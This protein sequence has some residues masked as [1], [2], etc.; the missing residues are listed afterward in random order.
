MQE[1]IIQILCLLD[2]SAPCGTSQLFRV[3]C[4]VVQPA[5]APHHISLQG[6][7][8]EVASG[9]C[10]CDMIVIVHAE[11]SNYCDETYRTEANVGDILYESWLPP[12]RG[13]ARYA[14]RYRRTYRI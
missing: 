8:P 14:R 9:E 1:V 13:S 4:G 12:V 11:W 10:C 5:A 7:P 2:S 6:E 3:R